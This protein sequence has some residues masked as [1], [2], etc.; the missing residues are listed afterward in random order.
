ML[1]LDAGDASGQMF[2]MLSGGRGFPPE[3]T[4]ITHCDPM[5]T[6][7][8]NRTNWTSGF[9]DQND[10]FT[11]QALELVLKSPVSGKERLLSP[12]SVL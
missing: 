11:F 4:C 2:P 10:K 8:E 12:T 6:L 1:R 5:T 3:D 9:E 7:G